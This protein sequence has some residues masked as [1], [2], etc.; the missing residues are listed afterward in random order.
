MC[1]L[2]LYHAVAPIQIKG[3]EVQQEI[4][5]FLE[6]S[7]GIKND[8][9]KIFGSRRTLLSLVQRNLDPGGFTGPTIF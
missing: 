8:F 5:S 3:S 6:M 4:I 1:H 7:W 9:R 2:L